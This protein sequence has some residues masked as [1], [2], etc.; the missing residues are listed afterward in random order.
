MSRSYACKVSANDVHER[1]VQWTQFNPFPQVVGGTFTA[2]SDT[3][4]LFNQVRRLK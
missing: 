2:L 3:E 1:C 4:N